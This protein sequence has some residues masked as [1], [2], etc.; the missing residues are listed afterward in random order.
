MFWIGEMVARWLGIDPL[1]T[2]A[3]IILL[4]LSVLR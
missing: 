1:L 4:P 3:A 2:S